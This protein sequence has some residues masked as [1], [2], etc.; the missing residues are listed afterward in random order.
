M[1]WSSGNRS[2]RLSPLRR[3]ARS[4]CRR[5][6]WHLKGGHLKGGI[7]RVVSQGG[8]LKG[9]I[10]RGASQPAERDMSRHNTHGSHDKPAQACS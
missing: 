1:V 7:S 9:G 5:R 6:G 3:I 10:S 8:H 2:R 4:T